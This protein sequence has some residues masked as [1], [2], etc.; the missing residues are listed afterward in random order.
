MAGGL[1]GSAEVLLLTSANGQVK[2]LLLSEE[3]GQLLCH[4]RVN[5]KGRQ[6][7]S[8]PG[9]LHV[10]RLRPSAEWPFLVFEEGDLASIYDSGVSCLTLLGF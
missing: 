2:R 3:E 4:L 7:E 8:L 9:K 10:P 6:S 5:R 1:I